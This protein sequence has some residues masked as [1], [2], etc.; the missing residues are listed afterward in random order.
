MTSVYSVDFFFRFVRKLLPV[1]YTLHT[2][3]GLHMVYENSMTK[4]VKYFEKFEQ[5]PLHT[6]IWN[7]CLVVHFWVLDFLD[8][9]GPGDCSVLDPELT[10]PP[11]GP[12]I[13]FM[14][15]PCLPAPKNYDVDL[16]E[17]AGMRGIL[18]ISVSVCITLTEGVRGYG[19]LDWLLEC[20]CVFH[21]VVDCVWWE[22][23]YHS[24]QTVIT[25]P[26]ET[27]HPPTESMVGPLT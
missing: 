8:N 14:N 17:G 25:S 23:L 1:L 6:L 13:H 27:V 12:N 5:Y 20:I 4:R 16:E 11:W 2:H 3:L 21:V 7:L 19:S 24:A 9:S 15:V 22:R 18:F 10:C 26:L